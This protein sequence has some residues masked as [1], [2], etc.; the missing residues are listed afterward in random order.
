M[1][2]WSDQSKS[3]HSRMSIRTSS[4]IECWALITRR[5]NHV[6]ELD[7]IPIT[8]SEP[9]LEYHFYPMRIS[10]LNGYAPSNISDFILLISTGVLQYK[11]LWL[12][13][14][15][16]Q[17]YEGHHRCPLASLP[18]CSYYSTLIWQWYR[19]YPRPFAR[20]DRIEILCR[21]TLFFSHTWSRRD[22]PALQVKTMLS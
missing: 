9:H 20:K 13:N 1:K 22:D 21:T 7:R 12:G 14:V 8:A 18:V 16:S 17:W 10:C 11:W 5:S 4:V 2:I 6:L 19:S 15:I 3:S